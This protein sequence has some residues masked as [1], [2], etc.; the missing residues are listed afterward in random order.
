M[1]KEVA[2][3]YAC[4]FKAWMSLLTTSRLKLVLLTFQPVEDALVGILKMSGCAV[5]G[6]LYL[7][8]FNKHV[9]S[10]SVLL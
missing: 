9:V 8:P 5:K 6:S 3:S 1:F 7:G 4:C 2:L 10:G